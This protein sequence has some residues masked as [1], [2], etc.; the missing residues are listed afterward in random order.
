MN[1]I[2]TANAVTR[3]SVI[4]ALSLL[5]R[6]PSVN[7]DLAPEEG[8][9]ESAVANAAVQWLQQRGVKAWT[10][11]VQPRRLNAVAEVGSGE[12]VLVFCG[13][14]DTVQTAGMTIAPFEP[15]IEDGKLYG[16]GS[17]DMK[18]GVA[19]IMCALEALARQNLKGR[20]L[21]A[22][23][24][25]EEVASIGAADF[26]RRYRA[27]GCVLTEPSLNG[28]R[29]LV[30]AHKGFVWAEIKTLGFATHGSRWDLG[31]S[32]IGKMGRIISA[33]EQFDRAV[34][35]QRVAPLV[36]PASLHC[37]TITGGTGWSTYAA[38][39][40]LRVERRTIP[41]E[42]PEQVMK[43][44]HEVIEQAGEEA[45]VELV[46]ARSPMVCAPDDRLAQCA[47]RAL[48]ETTGAVPLDA[49]VAYWMDA[50]IFHDAGIPTV[51]FGSTGAGAHEA[52]EWV[53]L[54][55]VH[56]TAEA[57]VRTAQRFFTFDTN[58]KTQSST[59][60]R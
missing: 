52:V 22:L 20:V 40:T 42:S 3:E 25:D 58:A 44:L 49:G 56:Q 46:L 8:H 33:L 18:G 57:L 30:L 47:R 23:V 24:A 17:F 5:V 35:R 9:D 19:A 34:L 27:D 39:C 29:E 48:E 1:V 2:M 12:R 7:P 51:N 59:E 11:E 55:T 6:T 31:V 26:V 21:A 50:A 38:E 60:R 36:G 37:A 14:I 32:A 45:D 13:H 4:D 10:E 53:D 16:R 54:E 41:G 43:E 15:R 28:P